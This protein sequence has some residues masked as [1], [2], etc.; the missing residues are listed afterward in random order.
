[1]ILEKP[2]AEVKTS[3]IS[4]P[5]DSVSN[6]LPTYCH[7]SND[8]AILLEALADDHFDEWMDFRKLT[9]I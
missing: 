1:M 6:F 5:F 3:R 4:N 9:Y 8:F 2:C 7:G